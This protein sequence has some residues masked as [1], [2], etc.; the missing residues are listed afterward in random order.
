MIPQKIK[1]SEPS[2]LSLIWNDGSESSIALTKLRKFCPCAT[3]SSERESQSN[4][5][6]P[7][8]H[9]GQTI[10]KKI[11]VIGNYAIGVIWE[12]GHNTG[13]YEF[14]LLKYLSEN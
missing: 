10:I 2:I 6:L 7:I 3:C 12:D 1:V 5:Y 9:S 11:N 8:Y 4:S 14:S 13:I